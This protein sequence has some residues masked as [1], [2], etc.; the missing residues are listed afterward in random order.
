M[1]SRTIIP[2]YTTRGDAEAFLCYPYIYNRTGEWIGWVTRERDVYSVLGVYVGYLSDDVRILRKITVEDKPH[3]TPPPKP[4]K[5][6]VPAMVPLAPLM[7]ELYRDTADVLLD[8]PER[9][10]TLD[11][12]ELRDDMD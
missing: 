8:E 2:I 11:A 9:L 5:I 3:H 7:K 1:D 6:L 12:G 4:G 10:H